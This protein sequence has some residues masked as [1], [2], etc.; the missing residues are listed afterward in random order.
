MMFNSNLRQGSFLLLRA[1]GSGG[2]S[3]TINQIAQQKKFRAK[4]KRVDKKKKG[5]GENEFLSARQYRAKGAV[6]VGNDGGFCVVPRAE[7]YS[8]TGVSRKVKQKFFL[9][10]REKIKRKGRVLKNVRKIFC[11]ARWVN[12]VPPLGGISP[13]NPLD[14]AQ[15][16]F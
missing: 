1:H 3:A 9:S 11:F 7:F 5:S 15:S 4:P 6:R 12:R 10:S 16:E 8:G 2:A 13:Q 14:F